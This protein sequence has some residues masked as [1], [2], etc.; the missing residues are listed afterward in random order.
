[1][2]RDFL[3]NSIN[4]SLALLSSQDSSDIKVAQT[5][6]Y[7]KSILSSFDEHTKAKRRCYYLN[8]KVKCGKPLNELQ[9]KELDELKLKFPQQDKSDIIQSSQ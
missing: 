5:Q 7:L 8:Q 4:H 2:K 9:Q 3:T 1:M 6:N